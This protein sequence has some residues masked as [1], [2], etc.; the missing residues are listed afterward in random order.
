MAK[1]ESN[2][3]RYIKSLTQT[4]PPPPRSHSG[5]LNS[6]L[7]I[8]PNTL[9][10]YQSVCTFLST[11]LSANSSSC[12]AVTFSL[13]KVSVRWIPVTTNSSSWL[14]S[15]AAWDSTKWRHH[16]QFNEAAINDQLGFSS[17]LLL[18]IML[19]WISLCFSTRILTP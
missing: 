16:N 18:Q 12:P 3:T 7:C 11:Q 8:F 2:T 10:A 1:K 9:Y 6:F 19:P 13:S 14:R 15:S 17:S 5:L 4:Q